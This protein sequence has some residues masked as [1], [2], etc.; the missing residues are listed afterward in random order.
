MKKFE[1]LFTPFMIG[2]LK[3]KNRLVMSPMGTNSA[4]PDGRISMD[5]V[6]YF[7]ARARG[8]VGLIITGTQFLTQDLAQG[9]LEGV[10]EKDY[11]IPM[12]T[13]LTES[14]QKYGT[15]II[16][17]L[18]CG[19][20]RNA[21]LDR[22]GK[23]P[24]SAS[25]IPTTMDPTLLCH[26]LTKE[27]ISIIMDQFSHSAGI[28]KRSGFDGIEVHAHAGY[29]IDQ[30][31]SPLWNKRE[32]EYGGSM[33]N[34]MRFP[35]E[36]VKAIRKAVGPNMPILF[37]ISV[38]HRFEGG[39]GLEESM[40]ML[41]ILEKAGVDALDI[42]AGSYE[43]IDY[44]FPPAYLGDA[45]MEYVCEPARKAVSIP[46]MN[47]GNHTPETAVQLIESGHADFAMLGRPLI[48]DPDLP[49]KL[50]L[51][52]REDIRPCIRC[53]EDC[54]GRI[55]GR[56]TKISCSVNPQVGFEHR[57]AIHKTNNTKKLV[58]VGGGP[59]GMEAARV[60]ALKGHSVTLFEKE[61]NLGGQL[62]SAATPPFK[63]KLRELVGWYEIQ[64]EKLGVEL[65]RN[66]IIESYHPILKE[67]DH[68]IVGPGAEA[69]V[70]PIPGINRKNVVGAI[71]SHLDKDLIKGNHIII[72]GG[73][74]TGC[75]LALELAME[76][77]DVSIIEMGDTLAPGILYINAV[78]L[79]RML[80]EFGVK[81]L[82]NHKV[83]AFED[84]GVMVETKEGEQQLIKADTIINAFGMKPNTRVVDEI[85]R[86]YPLKTRCIG[87][88]V[89]IGKVGQA[90]RTGFYAAMSL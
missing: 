1:V 88:G 79:N 78:S 25:A 52:Q 57:F 80:D 76:G 65:V 40:Q 48:A 22:A 41:K 63:S 2:N 17:Q 84:N 28:L 85:S 53:N 44:I 66:T 51:N 46:I 16:G 13:E 62:T 74:L 73:G 56:N 70:P 29:L 77:K 33:E 82:T 43:T 47:A 7:E 86:L 37:R 10:V 61:T 83:L 75:D 59:S 89:S 81:Q 69:I 12:L 54:I 3:V 27:E 42:D 8:G 31:M 71:E 34:R 21:L 20:G 9:V 26:P 38:D 55:I 19:T 6:D 58:I 68:I 4:G 24:V 67:A 15:K 87:D 30:F 5:E 23:P 64:L 50:L 49:N 11:V 36:I 32:D 72:T 45:C 60:A 35:V 39:R 90:V 18:S 14:V